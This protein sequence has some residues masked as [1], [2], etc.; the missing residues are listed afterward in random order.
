[1]RSPAI[2]S[3]IYVEDTLAIVVDKDGGMYLREIQ[4][5][6]DIYQLMEEFGHMPL[7]PY[8]KRDDEDFD[9]ERYQTVSAQDLGSVAALTA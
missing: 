6:K 3:E 7:P 4:G 2:G 9:A 1:N 8:M 5:D